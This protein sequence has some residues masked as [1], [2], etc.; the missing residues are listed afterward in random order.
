MGTPFGRFAGD[1]EA[2]G[3]REG[4][5]LLAD[6]GHHVGVDL[7]EVD[8]LD[9]VGELVDD[10]G[11]VAVPV[12]DV[13]GV[14]AQADV[15]GVGLLQVPLDLGLG[16]RRDCRRGDERRAASNSEAS[17]SPSW[18]LRL[19][20]RFHDPASSSGLEPFPGHQV[21]VHPGQETR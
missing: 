15:G 1:T 19:I 10:R 5:I 13:A 4:E 14:E 12:A 11:V 3:G 6:D 16:L 18:S 8:V 7:F 2:D 21:T 20:S 9:T 17:S